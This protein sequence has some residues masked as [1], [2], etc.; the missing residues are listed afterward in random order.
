METQRPEIGRRAIVVGN[1]GSGKTWFSVRLAEIT[2]LPLTHLDVLGWRGNWEKT[3]RDEFDALLDEVL[4]GESW[5]IDGNYS[6]TMPRRLERADTVFWFDFPGFRC[7]CGVVSRFFRDYGKSRADMG[8]NCVETFDS[9]KLRFFWTTYRG[10]KK[11]HERIA[12]LLADAPAG[13]AVHVFRKRRE[14]ERFLEALEEEKTKDP[15]G[16]TEENGK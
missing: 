13:L 14:A 5:I 1:C 10:A 12:G 6:R 16:R 3:P 8:G 15:A 7:L 11:T 9:E 4:S 2:G